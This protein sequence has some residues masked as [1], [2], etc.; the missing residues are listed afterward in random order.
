MAKNI[1]KIAA[2]VG[3]KIIG[4]VPNVGGGAFG[5]A[6]LGKILQERL[7]PSR[8]KRPGRPTDASWIHRP[9]VPMSAGTARKLKVLAKQASSSGRKVTATQI[10]A[11][12]LEEALAQ[13]DV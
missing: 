2:L 11:Q 4:K 8:G 10:A 12:L 9:K 6:R 7:E 3:G 13:C 5:M 1:E